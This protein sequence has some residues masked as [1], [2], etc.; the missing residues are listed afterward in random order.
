MLPLWG[1]P[2]NICMYF[3]FLETRI[4]DLYFAGGLHK[5]RLFCKDTY[6]PFK[7]VYFGTSQKHICDFLLVRRR[8]YLAPFQRYYRFSACRCSAHQ[9]LFH[10]NFRGW[11]RSPMLGS[12]RAGTLS[13]VAIKLSSKYSN[14]CDH[15]T[16]TLQ[17]YRQIDDIVWHNRALH[18]TA[19]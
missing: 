10:R 19:Q 9:L 11:T 14:L 7:A 17:T 3:I 2:A 18:S 13:Y 8:S 6:R 12:L 15:G 16:W 5:M 1:T 4:I